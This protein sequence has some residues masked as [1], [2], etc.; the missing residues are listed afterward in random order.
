M[1]QEDWVM[2]YRYQHWDEESRAMVVSSSM[3]TLETIR[4][5]LGMPLIETGQRVSRKALDIHGRLMIKPTR[6]ASS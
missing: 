2:V 4:N 6:S 3:A 5:G 1:N